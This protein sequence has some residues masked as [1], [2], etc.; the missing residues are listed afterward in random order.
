MENLENHR[1]YENSG[2]YVIKPQDHSNFEVHGNG[3]H[4]A[5]FYTLQEARDYIDE[6]M[7]PTDDI[8]EETTIKQD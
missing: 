6:T 8:G 3:S 1:L 5:D 7:K 4:Q 2:F